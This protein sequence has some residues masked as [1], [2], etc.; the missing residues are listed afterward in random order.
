MMFKFVFF[1]TSCTA[2]WSHVTIVYPMRKLS[3]IGNTPL[4]WLIKE[5][6]VFNVETSRDFFAI[7]CFVSIRGG[8]ECDNSVRLSRNPSIS[9]STWIL[10]VSLIM[11][12]AAV[13]TKQAT[14][15]DYV[16]WRLIA[17]KLFWS[18]QINRRGN[19]KFIC[20]GPKYRLLI[21]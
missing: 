15:K 20:L 16:C 10:I 6:S 3:K 1:H 8:F 21:S 18:C 11:W 4:V 9:G 13:K 12:K 7:T 14:R 17:G 2:H 5:Y 19:T